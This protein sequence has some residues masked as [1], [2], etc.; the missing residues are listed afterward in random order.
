MK[1]VGQPARGR[2][3]AARDAVKC[4]PKIT[5]NHC[6]SSAKCA[7]MIEFFTDIGRFWL[8]PHTTVLV[9]LIDT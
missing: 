9:N 4:V 5:R 3:M 1:P 6:P 2:E 8:G 7:R